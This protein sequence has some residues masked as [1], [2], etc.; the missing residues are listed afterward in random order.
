[1]NPGETI[2]PAASISFFP[3][4]LT[5]PTLLMEFPLIAISP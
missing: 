1:M 5:E 2:F 4:P 3:I